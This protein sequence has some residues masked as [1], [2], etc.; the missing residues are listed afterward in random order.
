MATNSNFPGPKYNSVPERDRQ[1]VSVPLE[2][3]DWGARA[4]QTKGSVK[5]QQ[6]IQHVKSEG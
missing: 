6:T 2:N 1:I 5:N 3:Q 4:S